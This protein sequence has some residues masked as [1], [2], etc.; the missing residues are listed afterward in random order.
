MK[1]VKILMGHSRN[2]GEAEIRA[3]LS[4]NLPND[5]LQ[6]LEVDDPKAINRTLKL[7]G[8]NATVPVHAGEEDYFPEGR[9][10]EGADHHV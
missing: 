5:V 3:F 2:M 10:S 4:K 7:L 8:I 6:A 9:A 1:I